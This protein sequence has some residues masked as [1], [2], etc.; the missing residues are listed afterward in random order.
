M[1]YSITLNEQYNSYEI[2]FDEKPNAE[3]RSK[4]KSLKFRWNP[5]KCIWYGFS[6]KETL[7]GILSGGIKED[8]TISPIEK[9]GDFSEGYL[10]ANR[11]DGIHSHDNFALKD[12]NKYLK[13]ICKKNYDVE[14][15]TKYSSYSMGQSTNI[16]VLVTK[17]D[18]IPFEDF[19]KLF[20]ETD[21]RQF[22]NFVF[23]NAFANDWESYSYD[24]YECSDNFNRMTEEQRNE[25]L[26]G[27][28]EWYITHDREYDIRS[29]EEAFVQLL[30][31]NVKKA[32]KEILGTLCSFNYD[33]SNGMVDYFDTN[34]YYFVY[35]NVLGQAK[36]NPEC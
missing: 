26:K 28:Y 21:D 13:Q 4:L 33:D 18:F 19:K 23:N 32:I 11:W 22:Y 36:E 6:D 15:R 34:F 29:S 5:K 7:E 12:I 16:R 30:K 10:G 17:D 35:V 20:Y 8:G 31:D 24:V 25:T 27:W 3:T 14:I 2:S 9:G 1:S